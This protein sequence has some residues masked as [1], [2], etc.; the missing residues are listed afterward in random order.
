MKNTKMKFLLFHFRK[1]YHLL[2]DCQGLRIR[3]QKGEASRTSKLYKN[4]AWPEMQAEVE[5]PS[6][7]L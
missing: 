2:E 4:L 6:C 1:R 5:N 3:S 7:E